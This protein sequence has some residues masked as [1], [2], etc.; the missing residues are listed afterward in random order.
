MYY[1]LLTAVIASMLIYG[2]CYNKSIAK[3]LQILYKIKIL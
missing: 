2:L 3:A 1:H